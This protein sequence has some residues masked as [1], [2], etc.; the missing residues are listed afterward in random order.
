MPRA[1]INRPLFLL[2]SVG[3][4]WTSN[5]FSIVYISEIWRKR[6]YSAILDS[7]SSLATTVTSSYGW[8][9]KR[10][11]ISRFYITPLDTTLVVAHDCISTIK[12]SFENALVSIIQHCSNHEIFIVEQTLKG[13]FGP[14]AD[15]LKN[16]ASRRL[17]TLNWN[18]TGDTL[19]KVIWALDDELPCLITAPIN[20]ETPV[21]SDQE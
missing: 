9:T 19:S 5:A 21:P 4:S 3:G 20:I 18:V 11:H 15:A 17:R 13:T 6:I 12:D 1:I 14:V 7:S 8:W 16:Y 10:I 2:V